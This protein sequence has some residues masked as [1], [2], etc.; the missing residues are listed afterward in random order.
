MK[1][2]I[3]NEVGPGDYFAYALT[4]GRSASLAVYQ[5][6]EVKNDK[7]RAIKKRESYGPKDG[8][9]WSQQQIKRK[10]VLQDGEHVYVD[11]TPE[12][13]EKELNK[14]STLGMFTERAL[15]IKDFNE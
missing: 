1:D 10:L 4:I 8:R 11:R 12:E 7:V 2:F 14:I 6:V 5:F 9:E 15:L 13:I 3:G